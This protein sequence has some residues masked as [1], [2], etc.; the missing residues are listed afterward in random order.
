MV[1]ILLCSHPGVGHHFGAQIGPLRQ[2]QVMPDGLLAQVRAL[3]AAGCIG[4]GSP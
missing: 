2:G 3:A 1:P 4:W